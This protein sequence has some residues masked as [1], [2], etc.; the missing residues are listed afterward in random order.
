MDRWSG[1]EIINDGRR[2]TGM[3][4]L[5]YLWAALYV[6]ALIVGWVL[7]VLSLPGNWLMVFAAALYAFF[8]PDD[9]RGG[10]GWGVVIALIVLATLGELL[11][12]LASALG[13]ARGGGSKR[14]AVLAVLGSIP[15]AILGSII[16]SALVPVVGTLIGVVVFAGLGAL[17]GAMLGE[18]WKGRKLEE[19]WK[20]GQSA[21]WGRVLGS[22]AKIS[23]ASIM[24][25]LGGLAVF[26]E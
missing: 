20:V 10:I 19:S 23:I 21:F 17:G 4:Y 7:T 5:D 11:E 12:L 26:L 15:G 25:A 2:I 8:M 9:W 16:G 1:R 14:S 6:L 13:A 3:E 18:W 22:V 24:L